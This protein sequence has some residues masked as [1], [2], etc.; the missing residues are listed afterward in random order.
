MFMDWKTQHS[1]LSVLSKF[2]YSF[3]AIPFEISAS[4]L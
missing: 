4:F 2:I 3:K 1:K